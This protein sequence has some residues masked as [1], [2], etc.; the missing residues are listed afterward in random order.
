M[1]ILLECIYHLKR[2]EHKGEKEEK[3]HLFAM[4]N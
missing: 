2:K 4:L 3:I 1:K